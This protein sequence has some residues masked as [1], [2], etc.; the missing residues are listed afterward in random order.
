VGSDQND[1]LLGKARI[2]QAVQ[3]PLGFFTL[4]VLVIEV[5]L[6]ILA[7]RATGWNYSVL[8]GAIIISF[9]GLISC[10]VFITLRHPE[11]LLG[12][13]TAAEQQNNPLGQQLG[14]ANNEIATL[15]RELDS[16][17]TR[18]SRYKE[19]NARYV[20][21]NA[22]LR[23]QNAELTA[24][25]RRLESLKN[26]VWGLLHDRDA[27]SLDEVFDQLGAKND[28][29][30]KKEILSTLTTLIDEGKAKRHPI[31]KGWFMAV[32]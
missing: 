29:S 17:D 19:E 12:A 27:V 9:F 10:V 21:E 18:A 5:I 2:I 1:G 24:S 20:E 7:S 8:L 4:A 31:S 13:N 25:L 16:S 14:A 3:T 15:R 6:G 26:S 32:D 30:L 28:P 23:D 11:M 22:G